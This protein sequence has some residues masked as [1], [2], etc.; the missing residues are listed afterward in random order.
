MAKVSKQRQSALDEEI[1]F[2]KRQQWSVA[3]YAL[4]LLGALFAITRGANLNW[5]EI[6]AAI[7]LIAAIAGFGSRQIWYLQKHLKDLRRKIGESEDS[8]S[9]VLCILVA[10]LSISALVVAYFLWRTA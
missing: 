9:D 6:L 4:T 7:V 3:Y 2:A 10:A 1:R 5:A 8:P